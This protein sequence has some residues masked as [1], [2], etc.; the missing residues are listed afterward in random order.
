MRKL[1]Q[2]EELEADIYKEPVIRQMLLAAVDRADS[3]Q[4]LRHL[5]AVDQDY[6]RS[7][8]RQS[9]CCE[10][11]RF[12]WV[13]RNMDY[14][15]WWSAKGSQALWLS[16]PAE[17]DISDASSCIVDLAKEKS[18]E[19]QYS[20]LYFF[21]SDEPTGVP[22]AITFVSTIVSQLICCLPQLKERVTKVFLRT[23]VKTI[24]SE[25]IEKQSR[26]KLG[27]SAEAIVKKILQVS[28]E[29][30]WSALK[31]VM[32]LERKQEIF[33]VID[34]LDKAGREFISGVPIIIEGLQGY[35][36]TI[37]VLITSRPQAEIKEILGGLP[38]IEYDKERKGLITVSLIFR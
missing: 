20:A 17:C 5:S 31:A 33:L 24:L 30:Y 29:V 34:G 15:R 10:L 1:G 23:L 21:C 2:R 35:P 27:D 22:I 37:R 32:S 38:Y 14:E 9:S 12:Y 26:F 28:S 25:V 19:A 7:H 36:S 8:A 18:T 16:G 6:Y 4:L 3:D 13:F 11:P